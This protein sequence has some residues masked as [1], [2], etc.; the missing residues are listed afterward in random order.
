MVINLAKHPIKLPLII[1]HPQHL[2]PIKIEPRMHQDT[3]EHYP[4]SAGHPQNHPQ[5]RHYHYNT[6]PHA[7]QNNMSFVPI[8]PNSVHLNHPGHHTEPSTPTTHGF[9]IPPISR[10]SLPMY[11]NMMMSTPNHP[12]YHNYSTN[13]H[14]MPPYPSHLSREGITTPLNSSSVPQTPSHP[15]P[16]TLPASH[17]E[18]D[19]R[20]RAENWHYA[21]TKQFVQILLMHK[22]ELTNLRRHPGVWATI[23]TQLRGYGYERSVEKCK[24]RWKVLVAKYKK[25]TEKIA[26]NPK[27]KSSDGSQYIPKG[28]A[29]HSGQSFDN[30]YHYYHQQIQQLNS[31]A[32][33]FEFYYEMHELLSTIYHA[34]PDGV[35]KRRQPT[36]RSPSPKHFITPIDSKERTEKELTAKK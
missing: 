19:I 31:G 8:M 23:A 34:G 29:P 5:M 10:E 21:E 30:N 12:Y 33:N 24:N 13:H 14:A 9:Q 32:S 3:H 7:N 1:H 20:G 36:R 27:V 17:D 2:Q 18:E 15:T 4:Q 25:Y 6:Q 11:N 22:R 26:S 28:G 35:V 16:T